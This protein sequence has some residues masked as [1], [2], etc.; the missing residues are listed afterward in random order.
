MVQLALSLDGTELI[1][2]F[3]PLVAEDDEMNMGDPDLLDTEEFV[4]DSQLSFVF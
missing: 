2:E 4:S 1:E 3:V